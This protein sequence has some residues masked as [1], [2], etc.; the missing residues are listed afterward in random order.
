MTNEATLNKL[1]EMHL[2]AMADAFRLQLNDS[3]MADIP[4]EDRFGLMVDREYTSR[5]NNRLQRLIKK[6]SFDQSQANVN[7][8]NYQAGRKLNKKLIERL[9]TCV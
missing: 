6:A 5:K 7:D 3:S 9:S 2:S 1:V 8:I 4:F